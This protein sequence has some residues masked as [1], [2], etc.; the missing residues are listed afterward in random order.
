MTNDMKTQLLEC[1]HSTL[2]LPKIRLN[3]LKIL[4]QEGIEDLPDNVLSQYPDLDKRKISQ[5]HR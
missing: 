2:V 1:A 4:I 5:E 3:A